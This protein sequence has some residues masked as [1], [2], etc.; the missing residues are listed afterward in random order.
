MDF[1]AP[2]QDVAPI[3][4]QRQAQPDRS[5][6]PDLSPP[7][8]PPQV[9]VDTRAPDVVDEDLAATDSVDA[10]VEDSVG[11]QY[12]AGQWSADVAGLLEGLWFISESDEPFTVF[13]AQSANT[14][15]ILAEELLGL[16]DAAPDSLVQTRPFMGY[17][18]GLSKYDENVAQ[19]DDLDA[20]FQAKLTDLVVIR[21]GEIEIDVYIIGRTACGEVVGVRTMSVET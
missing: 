18:E 13:S 12:C 4:D 15:P 6:A 8:V 9:D 19:Y 5:P 21:V 10:T 2:P 3:L 17:I 1:A 20:L 16:I 7:D 14:G 11:P